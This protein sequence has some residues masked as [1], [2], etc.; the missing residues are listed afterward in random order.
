[1]TRLTVLLCLASCGDDNT[2]PRNDAGNDNGNGGNAGSNASTGTNDGSEDDGGQQGS[3]GSDGTNGDDDED[4]GTPTP[5][6]TAPTVISSD[7]Q[8]KATGTS[9]AAEIMVN[10]SEAMA[11]S[12][13]TAT[14]FSL[15]QGSTAIAGTVAYFRTT[16]S[17]KPTNNL[18]AGTEYTATLTTEAEDLAGNA[19]KDTHVWSFT[20]DIM[21]RLGPAPVS[22]GAAGAYIIL[23]KSAV[24]NVP[25]SKLTGDIG[26]SPAAA[27]FITGFSL[28][29]A[30]TKWTS[31]QITGSAYAANNDAPTPK[32]LTTAVGNMETAYTD[33]ASR[34][35]PTVLNAGAG[36]IG[37]MTLVPGL[38]K[39]TSS[40]TIPT[41]LTLAGGANDVWIFQIDGDLK[42]SAATRVILSGGA[43]AKN[44]VWQ[45]AGLV[46]LATTAHAEGV[47][48][49]KTAINLGTG[50]SINGRLL[51]QT[52]VTLAGATVVTP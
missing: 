11:A 36:T 29:R 4:A 48:L 8:D 14:T 39:W 2:T 49:C 46:D 21:A 6:T 20:T 5:D 22:L 40:V 16:A 50:A 42:L 15:A 34:P 18:T 52:A 47:I 25:T 38:Y 28:T 43:Q 1:M 24:T 9:S 44:I 37:G 45:V 7:P 12:T 51:A 23:A 19:L 10:F 27:T 3:G 17:F 33:A 13:I 31:S 35:T 41:D 26:I 30:G 32:N